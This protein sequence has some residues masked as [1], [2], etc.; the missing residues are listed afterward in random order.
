M[1][2]P[3]PSAHSRA[4]RPAGPFVLPSRD[5]ALVLLICLAWAGN[6]LASAS[7]LQHFPPFVF[8]AL[9]LVLVLVFLARY[10]RPVPS[11][12]RKRLALVALCNGALHFG[13]NF[14]AIAV[15]GDISSV[16]LSL[17]SY[18]PMT[19]LL[20]WW[21]LGERPTR[22]TAIGIG[23]AFIGVAVLGFDPL[24]LDAPLALGLSLIAAAALA[25]GTTLL[26][27]LPGLHTF[28]IQAWSAAISIPPLL[29]VALLTEPV[30]VAIFT[31]ARWQDWAGVL[32]SALAASLVG[33]G[34]LYVLLQRHAVAQVTPL[35]LLTPVFA[36]TLGVLFWGDR[37]GP[38]LLLGGA[39]VLGGVLI[40]AVRGA[41]R[42]R[43]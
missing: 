25:L 24:V 40:V 13:F 17:Q 35:L 28:Q 18:I 8:T 37:P 16:A 12:L 30:T 34:L 9:R 14:W 4:S 27:S 41:V 31:D 43:R 5:L 19:A 26:R 7:A 2:T 21:L 1:P 20:A 38:R 42:A 22:S 23:V 32:Y 33:H 36:V 39:M 29:L 10:L 3:V 6:F 11:A 15:A